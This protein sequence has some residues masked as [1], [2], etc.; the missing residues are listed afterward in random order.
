MTDTIAAVGARGAGAVEKRKDA[1]RS[2]DGSATVRTDA[3]VRK[4]AASTE[5]VNGVVRAMP[6][7]GGETRTRT[8]CGGA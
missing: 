5:S 2:D 6:P 1:E 7:R 4:D 8:S 3:S